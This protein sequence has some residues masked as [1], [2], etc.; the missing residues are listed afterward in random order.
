MED[1]N[2]KPCA[3]N[4]ARAAILGAATAL[5][6]IWAGVIGHSLYLGQTDD[7]VI[8]LAVA[9]G[10]LTAIVLPLLDKGRPK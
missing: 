1:G 3:G 9:V 6:L 2:P 4:P 8:W 5:A 7:A 10:S